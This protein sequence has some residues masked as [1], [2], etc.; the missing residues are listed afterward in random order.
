MKMKQMVSLFIISLSLWTVGVGLVP[1]LPLYAEKLGADP[2]VV[3]YYL[4]FC[5]VAIACGAMAA[6]WV[7]DGLQGRKLPLLI[8]GILSIPATW[9]MSQA[10]EIISLSLL[11][12][13][14]WFC[15]GFGL[16]GAGILTGLSAREDERGKYFGI[17]SL[18][19]GL[20]TL[21]G[22]LS[23]GYIV[24]HWGYSVLFMILAGFLVIWPIANLFLTEVET[25]PAEKKAGPEKTPGLGRP[26]YLLLSA[27]LIAAVTG[28]IVTLVRSL[29]M[30]DMGFGATAIGSTGA[31]GGLVTLPL[32]L[33]VGWLSDRRGRK[34]FL[35]IGYGI[36]AAS[37]A[38]L[39]F[40]TALWHFWVF[41]LLQSLSGCLTGPVGNALATDVLPPQALGKGLGVFSTAGWIGGIVGF[42]LGGLALKSLGLTP[43]LG[44]AI[45]M[46][47]AAMLLLIPIRPR[48]KSDEQEPN[49]GSAVGAQ[50]QAA[51]PGD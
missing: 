37:V 8:I 28:F 12:A 24:D 32:P 23:T 11:T 16:S 47:L 30:N 50:I 17:L 44:I 25:K 34:V 27:S 43:T 22:G 33:L 26:F 21:I 48:E 4:A 5:Y 42:A 10:R 38:V 20:G 7:S 36:G 19:S 15:G 41:A 31:I 9:L 13:V 6:G 39:A 45:G 49:L 18:T 2:S 1:L 46:S 40:S 14:L 29:V 35:Y 3:G 51:N